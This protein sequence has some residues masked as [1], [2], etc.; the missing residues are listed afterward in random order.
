MLAEQELLET[1]YER[2][3]SIRRKLQAVPRNKMVKVTSAGRSDS[4]CWDCA[5]CWPSK[6]AWV[7]D[8]ELVWDKAV[9][10][11]SSGQALGP[12][13]YRVQECRLFEPEVA[14]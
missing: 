4:I 6:C 9:R 10:V 2:I 11:S 5:N 1:Q 12:F 14:T 7:A 13:A 3:D 8:L